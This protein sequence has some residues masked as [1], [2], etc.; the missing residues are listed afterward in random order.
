MTDIGHNTKAAIRERAMRV[1]QERRDRVE[2][3]KEI[4]ATAIAN[5]DLTKLEARAMKLSI[6]RAFEDE[7]KRAMRLEI[8]Q[9]ALSFE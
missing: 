8:E 3:L 9:L 5:K 1:E 2:D 6:R 7:A 4:F